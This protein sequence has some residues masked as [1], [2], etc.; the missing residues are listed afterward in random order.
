[1]IIGNKESIAVFIQDIEKPI[2]SVCL[3][4]NGLPI[5]DYNRNTLLNSFT[6]NVIYTLNDGGV[7]PEPFK[8]QEPKHLINL[9]INDD[10]LNKYINFHWNEIF[11]DFLILQ[12]K[13]NDHIFLICKILRDTINYQKNS[14]IYG[15][16]SIQEINSLIEEFKIL[17]KDKIWFK[18]INT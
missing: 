17:T 1:M 5:G 11:D 16:F 6:Y 4:L 13:E 15:N 3:Y 18:S 10:L 8:K 2:S 9:A 7:L 14:I 12:Y